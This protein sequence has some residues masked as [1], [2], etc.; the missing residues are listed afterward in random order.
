[1]KSTGIVRPVDS[2]GRV[3]LPVEL[4]R[5][6]GIEYKDLIEIYVEGNSIVLRKQTDACAI[7]GG[8]GTIDVGGKKICSRCLKTIKAIEK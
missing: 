3:V 1:M 4:R 6:L 7:C 5:A 8:K 2:L